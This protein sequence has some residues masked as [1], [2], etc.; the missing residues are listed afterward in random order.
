MTS[1]YLP[2]NLDFITINHSWILEIYNRQFSVMETFEKPSLEARQVAISQPP[3]AALPD[4]PATEIELNAFHRPRVALPNRLN[5]SL[6]THEIASTGW[7]FM[8]GHQ[9]AIHG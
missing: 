9:Q 5:L 2:T 6:V 8:G 4:H 3:T 7:C 1:L